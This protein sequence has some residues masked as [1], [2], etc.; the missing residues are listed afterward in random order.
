MTLFLLFFIFLLLLI[1][2][3]QINAKKK[4]IAALKTENQELLPSNVHLISTYKNLIDLNLQVSL[5]S[6]FFNNHIA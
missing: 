4:E 6:K 3:S 1:F 2:I 5:L